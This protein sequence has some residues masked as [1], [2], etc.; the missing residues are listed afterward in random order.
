MEIQF[1]TF[2]DWDYRT[3][4]NVRDDKRVPL[5]GYVEEGVQYRGVSMDDVVLIVDERGL[6]VLI[7]SDN[8]EWLNIAEYFLRCGNVE[9]QDTARNLPY[10]ELTPKV[11]KGLGFAQVYDDMSGIGGDAEGNP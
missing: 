2:N 1:N 7:R 5:I 9:A 4:P 6:S 8:P 11:F 3:Y 10:A